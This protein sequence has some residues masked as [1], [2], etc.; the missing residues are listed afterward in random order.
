MHHNGD[1]PLDFDSDS[2]WERDEDEESHLNRMIEGRD[3][4]EESTF[5]RMI[6]EYDGDD[7]SNSTSIIEEHDGDEAS[8]STS[9]I[10][11]HDDDEESDPTRIIEVRDNYKYEWGHLARHKCTKRCVKLTGNASDATSHRCNEAC[12]RH[13]CWFD[14][15]CTKC[16]WVCFLL[17]SDSPTR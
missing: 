16:V 10:E 3:V 5:N 4:E 15:R 9:I 17:G 1:D 12:D 13:E 6:E 2:D 7:E 14:K 11:G 8:N